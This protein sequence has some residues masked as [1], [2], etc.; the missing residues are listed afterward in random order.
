MMILPVYVEFVE[1][2]SE[3]ITNYYYWQK[4][5]VVKKILKLSCL[6]MICF[7]FISLLAISNTQKESF[8][9]SFEVY[10]N[11]FLKYMLHM[12]NPSSS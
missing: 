11:F 5:K 2:V 3:I 1:E 7:F 9:Y 10:W 8:I 6:W 12:N 4:W